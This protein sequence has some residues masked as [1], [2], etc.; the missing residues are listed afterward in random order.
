MKI[1]LIRPPA[2]FIKGA[3]KPAISLPTGL[4]YLAAVLEQTNRDVRI[5]DAQVN[6]NR[7]VLQDQDGT[8][9]MGDDWD[10][11]RTKI[12]EQQ[13]DLVG[14]SC[15]FSAQ[16]ENA[17]RLAEL[18]K[19]VNPRIVTIVGGSHPTVRPKDFFEMTRAIDLVC[20]GEGEYTLREV[21]EKLNAG[22]TV[23]DT[24][25]VAARDGESVRINAPRPRITPLDDLPL[26]AYHL[27]DLEDYFSLYARGY[28]DR[29]VPRTGGFER[30]VSLI[31]SRGCPHQ[32]IFCSVHLHMG[33]G[34]RAHSV[35]YVQRHLG[36][37]TNTYGVRHIHFEDDNVSLDAGR[38]Q[39]ILKLL[40]VTHPPLSWDTPNGLRVDTLT[41]EILQ[42]CRDSG[43]IYLIFGVE[44]G[45]QQVLDNVVNKRLELET[46]VRASAWAKEIGIDA[47]AFYV[48]GFPKETKSQ[49]EDTI[50]FAVRLQ[51]QY[52]ITPYLFVATPLPGTRLESECIDN[53][54]IPHALSPQDL[55]K[56]TQGAIFI[57]TDTF[58]AADIESIK[59]SFLKRYR[60]NII[61]QGIRLAIQNPL[62]SLYLLRHVVALWQVIP[63]SESVA[64]T[65][66]LSRWILR[67]R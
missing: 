60:K 3:I 1:L 16:M 59:N 49:M 36:L 65:L 21:V 5:Y 30:S 24:L 32:C 50:N 15:M 67:S 33:R 53:G 61:R 19:Q 47:M 45:N 41:K 6:R 40:Q 23:S 20:L 37:L 2:K 31:T 25:G 56:M 11:V 64:R 39:G 27:L 62:G 28:T 66:Q 9:H 13:P 26:P 63:F 52:G 7:P 38:F 58:S 17:L 48:I 29:P 35:D 57:S 51:A 43:C 22:L 42:L 4:L 34:W 8:L 55:A 14:I 46:V 18:V 44:S 54:Y 10:T 12:T